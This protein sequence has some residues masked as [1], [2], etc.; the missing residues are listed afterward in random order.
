MKNISRLFGVAFL[1]TMLSFALVNV[2]AAQA[3]DRRGDRPEIQLTDSQKEKAREIFAANREATKELR[4]TIK[5][6]REEL[7]QL[8]E[9]SNPDRAR[10]EALSTELGTLDGKMR[11]NRLDL[12][13]QLEKEGLP[14]ELAKWKDKKGDKK[15][16]D[17]KRAEKRSHD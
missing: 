15:F 9:S 11:L 5:S 6:K 2:D 1:A 4:D 14:P 16:R 8:M 3:K 13:S 17:K 10:I 7:K 12:R